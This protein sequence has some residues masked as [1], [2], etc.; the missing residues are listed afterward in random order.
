MNNSREFDDILNEC[1]ESILME[2]R[3]IGDCLSRYPEHSGE[4]QPLLEAIYAARDAADTTP[5][6]EFRE[7]A[8]H[9]FQSAIRETVP[10]RAGGIFGWRPQWAAVLVSLLVLLLGGGGTVAAAAGSMPD[11]AL[12]PVKR[13]TETVRL[14]LTPSDLGKAELYAELVDRRINEITVM[15]ER[16]KAAN[17]EK[18]T[19]LL[20]EQLISMAGLVTRDGGVSLLEAPMPMVAESTPAAIQAPEP[21]LLG[22]A[23]PPAATPPMPRPSPGAPEDKTKE[24]P[25]RTVPTVSGEEPETREEKLKELLEQKATQN[26]EKLLEALQKAPAELQPALEKA[27]DIAEGGYAQVLSSLEQ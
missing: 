1:L 13:A 10:M 22:E 12:Y 9:E 20:S 27:R 18:T 8:R 3:T 11:G 6:P 26:Q 5:S 21:P 25:D 2:G 17:L 15:A 19:D 14:V 16:G 7:K 4:L 23:P 24:M